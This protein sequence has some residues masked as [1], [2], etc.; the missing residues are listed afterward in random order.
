MVF[1]QKQPQMSQQEPKKN[2]SP[3]GQMRDHKYA[4]QDLM[5]T[6]NSGD[7]RLL[8]EDGESCPSTPSKG[9]H[10]RK[11]SKPN[12]D[13][14]SNSA[15]LAA[16]N[17]LVARFDTQEKKFEEF[18]VQL[19]QNCAM[20]TSLTRASNFNAAEVK[21]CKT[22]VSVLE[23]EVEHLRA[24]NAEIK[25]KASEQDRYKRRWNL[26]IRGMAEKMNEDTRK[27]VIQLL[28]K[29]APQWEKNM[30]DI[31]D[32]VH[33]IGRKT[34]NK[35]RQIIIQFTRRQHRDAFWKLTKESRVCTEAGIRFMEDLTK[36]DRMAREALW[37][38]IDQ[39]RKNGEKAYF[40]GPFG[41]INGRRIQ[42]EAKH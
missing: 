33:R 17:T 4:S 9:A 42:A 37:P 15:I 23:K 22:R 7:K 20:I 19:K 1:K 11:I 34:E 3:R 8:E 26:R 41:F 25:E 21:D 40:R 13:E 39:A 38:R 12:E 18:G 5:D 35:T 32:T 30:E 28:C 27:D 31:V 24:A 2:L 16:I 6:D 36:E 29:I 10:T 14:V